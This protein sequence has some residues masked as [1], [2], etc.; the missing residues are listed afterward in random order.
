MQNGERFTSSTLVLV[1]NSQLGSEEVTLLR[2]AAAAGGRVVAW[3]HPS[4]VQE[5]FPSPDVAAALESHA[6]PALRLAEVLGEETSVEVDEAVIAWMKDFGRR[7]LGAGG[8]SFRDLF[9]YRHLSLWWWAELF[10][11]HDT[12]LRLLVRDVEALAR[13]LEK[14]RPERLVVVSPVRE[15]AAVAR[16]MGVQVAVHGTAGL[17]PSSHHQTSRRFIGGLL[18]M[19]GTALKGFL[20]RAPEGRPSQEGRRRW[21]FLT[22]ASMWRQRPHPETGEPELVE[23]YFDQLPASLASAGDRVKL[24][25]V[26]P[27]VPFKQRD[28]ETLLK[29]VLELERKSRPYVSIR[30]YFAP[31]MCF[32]LASAFLDCRKMWHAFRRLPRLHEALAHRGAFLG[33]SARQCFR[34]TFLLQLPW[35]IRSYEEI[36][37]VLNQDDPDLLILYAESSGMGRAAVAA[38]KELGIPSFAVQHGIMYPRYYS[39]EHAPHEVGPESDGGETVPIPTRTAVFGSLARDLLVSRGCLPPERI[40]IT[41]SPKFD[42]LVE[43]AR[44]YDRRDTRSRLGIGGDGPMLVVATRFSAIGPVFDELV[45]AAESI[46]ELWLVVKPH[47]AEPAE[48]YRQVVDEVGASRVRVI[49]ASENLMELLVASDGLITV[50]SLASSEALVLGRPVLV[51]NLP[52]NLGPLVDRGVALGVW[53]GESIEDRLRKM[54]FD[55]DSV[56]ELEVRRK[57]YIQEFAFGADGGS[58]QRILEAMRETAKLRKGAA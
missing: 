31:G 18:K 24:V 37:A 13:L 38:A 16:Q 42:A 19:L 26:G 52:S 28:L 39:H 35:A 43:S 51:V 34:D 1:S 50:D 6:I 10:L 11:Y 30:D 27:P 44:R 15:L 25:A 58:T 5:R 36:R 4:I 40:V 12:S 7:P 22:H 23:M 20:R 33:S 2:E 53:Q 8:E 54:L 32:C 56:S 48:P 17:A 47:Q 3:Q 9:R 45:R 14:E 21:L 29:D 55:R 46:S 49:A 41:G 57:E